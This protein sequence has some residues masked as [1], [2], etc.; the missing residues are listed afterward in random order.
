MS[1]LSISS[2]PHHHI[3]RDTGQ[4]MRMVCYACIPGILV[5]MWFFGFGVLVQ[6]CLGIVTALVTEGIILELRKKRTERILKDYSAVLTAVLLAISIPPL[7]PWWVI[8]IGTFFSIA[9]VKQLY[10]GLGFNMF[11]PA[12]AGYVML[13]VSFPVAMTSW[14]PPQSIAEQSHNLLDAIYTVFTGFTSTGFSIEQLKVGY[15]GITMATPLD[16]VKT[17]LVQGYTVTEAQQHVIFDGIYGKGWFWMSLA[18]LAGG[19]YLVKTKVINWHIPGSMILGALGAFF[20]ATD[21]VSASTTNRGRLIFGAA[22]GVWIIIIRQ[23]GGYPD[24]IAFAVLIM[25]M[26]VPLIDYYTQP[27]T[28]GHRTKQDKAS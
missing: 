25:N 19:I 1:K 18:Y 22:I 28:Y 16:H 2:S 5:N 11:N 13:L 12:M 10:G 4:V 21:P 26:A 14:I 3:R 24:A 8:V 17:A 6:L 9:V 15:D 7:A 27:R 23:W 20:I